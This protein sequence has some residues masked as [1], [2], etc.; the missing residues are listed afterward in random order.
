MLSAGKAGGRCRQPV[1]QSAFGSLPQLWRR[2]RS[3]QGRVG[4]R[5][6]RR[7]WSP[8]AR[9]FIRSRGELVEA[10]I[11]GCLAVLD[12]G[13]GAVAGFEVRELPS[14]GVGGEC[15]V[16]P[17]VV[18]LER[19]SC[20]PGC[21]RSRRAIIRLPT[22]YVAGQRGSGQ[23]AGDLGP[24]RAPSRW[25]LLAS[26]AS[27]QTRARMAVTAA[28]S[29]SRIAQ[30]TDAD[31]LHCVEK[32]P[33]ESGPCGEVP[34]GQRQP[35]LA[36][37]TRRTSATACSGRPKCGNPRLLTTASKQRSGKGSACASRGRAAESA[38]THT[39]V[40]GGGGC[41]RRVSGTGPI[42][43][44]RDEREDVTRRPR[45]GA[46]VVPSANYVFDPPSQ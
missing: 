46:D 14:G 36:G 20:A 37:Q 23:H 26:I 32:N 8:S 15:L 28:R 42:S 29:L 6:R 11:F 22:G 7:A 5:G 45:R 3:G 39:E 19:V 25:P 24:D 35:A 34:A 31:L 40:T 43:T 17:A 44:G 18:L 38:S 10:G 9:R 16:A 27:A 4:R 13:V 12:P 30:P 2:R 1:A 21:G 33:D 41:I